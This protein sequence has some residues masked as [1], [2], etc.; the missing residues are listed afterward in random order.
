VGRNDGRGGGKMGE[1]KRSE[2]VTC[3]SSRNMTVLVVGPVVVYVAVD[4]RLYH[5]LL[6]RLWAR[7]TEREREAGERR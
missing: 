6:E 5:V 4:G 3:V 7:E 1:P 2:V